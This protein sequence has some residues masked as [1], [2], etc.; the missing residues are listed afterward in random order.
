M[1]TWLGS[2]GIASHRDRAKSPA[3]D[4]ERVLGKPTELFSDY[5]SRLV[6]MCRSIFGRHTHAN[7]GRRSIVQDSGCYDPFGTVLTMRPPQ[8]MTAWPFADS[9]GGATNGARKC[10]SAANHT[11]PLCAWATDQ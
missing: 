1:Q 7:F 5:E 11:R 2:I 6:V 3:S 8:F 10:C 9:R 4:N